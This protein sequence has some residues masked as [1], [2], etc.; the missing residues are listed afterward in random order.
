MNIF[1][2]S[3]ELDSIFDEL[4]ELKARKNLKVTEKDD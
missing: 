4:E 1:E 3:R 2:I